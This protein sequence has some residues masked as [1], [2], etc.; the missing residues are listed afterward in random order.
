MN[1]FLNNTL[2]I[3]NI[4]IACLT[5]YNLISEIKKYILKIN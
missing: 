1:I 3:L 4:G 2:L 5:I